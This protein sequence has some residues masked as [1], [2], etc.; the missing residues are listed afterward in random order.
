[1][2]SAALRVLAIPESLETILQFLPERDLLLNQR[3]STAWQATTTKSPALQKQLH[4]RDN[5]CDPTVCAD[6][7]C[8][9]DPVHKY[10]EWALRY[11]SMTDDRTKLPKDWLAPRRHSDGTKGDPVKPSWYG[12]FVTRPAVSKIHVDFPASDFERG[13]MNRESTPSGTV[14]NADDVTMGQIRETE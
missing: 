9:L 6:T 5:V 11:R 3:V 4:Y 13:M 8:D 12:M 7:V 10:F 2:V 1:M 14:T